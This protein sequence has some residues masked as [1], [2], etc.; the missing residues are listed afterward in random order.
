MTSVT[1]SAHLHI[2]TEGQQRLELIP[3]CTG[4]EAAT[5]IFMFKSNF[6]V[7]LKSWEKL[8]L[9]HT[10]E[11]TCKLRVFVLK[12]ASANCVSTELAQMIRSL[13]CLFA[14]CHFL[15]DL[16]F[17]FQDEKLQQQKKKLQSWWF[18]FSNFSDKNSEKIFRH[19]YTGIKANIN[20]QFCTCCSLINYTSQCC[21]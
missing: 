11:P 5:F 1:R 8:Q 4:P 15:Q 18:F 2:L 3:A 10:K 21:A 14:L 19:C 9:S 13:C 20:I 6:G 12:A 7:F 16:A 17:K